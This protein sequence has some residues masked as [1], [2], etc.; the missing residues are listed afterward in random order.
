MQCRQKRS[1]DTARNVKI[2]FAVEQD[3]DGYPPFGAESM[4]AEPT[5]N[6]S[7][8]IQNIPFYAKGV[9]RGDIVS[10]WFDGKGLVY[11]KTFSRSAN[12]TI[13]AVLFDP[14]A[15]D[16]VV[17]SLDSIGCDHE[18]HKAFNLVAINVR[19][20]FSYLNLLAYLHSIS[21]RGLLD[22]EEAT[23]RF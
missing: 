21:E 16:D 10:A 5:S 19:D 11:N 15:V 13:R 1:L 2:K 18:W 17:E 9:S 4:W 20:E 22:F 8:L 23:L 12:S 6:D 3:E 7:Y 14:S